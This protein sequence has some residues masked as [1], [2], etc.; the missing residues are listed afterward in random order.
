[1]EDDNTTEIDNEQATNTP[2]SPKGTI[3]DDWFAKQSVPL[4]EDDGIQDGNSLGDEDEEPGSTQEGS[5]MPGDE[6]AAA[7]E[8]QEEAPPAQ[9][10]V[11]LSK[12][13]TRLLAQEKK[14]REER[15]KFYRERD[16]VAQ[17]LT[18]EERDIL[19]DKR[20]FAFYKANI[21]TQPAAA[22]RA[23]GIS[24]A[25]LRDA[26]LDEGKPADPTDDIRS[27]LQALKQW[28][29]EQEKQSQH[30]QQKQALTDVANTIHST[31]FDDSLGLAHLKAN[32]TKHPEIYDEVWED[33]QRLHKK[34]VTGD[35]YVQAARRIN[36][37][38]A[39]DESAPV[40]R[41]VGSTTVKPGSGG[42][43][44]QK[45]QATTADEA[46]ELMWQREGTK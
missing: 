15:A 40:K 22:L 34:G 20:R 37:L 41:P 6:E 33:I 38:Y 9:E 31:V 7:D 27:E 43:S 29:Q 42:G 30:S 14:L 4:P 32:V 35:L 23:L 11:R 18:A 45:R 26:I 25:Q 8:Q 17:R 16:E 5:L 21:N 13:A 12:A 1:M 36:R 3:D 46:F 44:T 19:E 39:P 24:A 28:K 2:A 10:T